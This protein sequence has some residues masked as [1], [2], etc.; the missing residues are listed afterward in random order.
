MSEDP[1][2]DAFGARWVLDARALDPTARDRLHH[3]W[4]RCRVPGARLGDEGVEPFVVTDPD[5]Y[6]VSRAL[7]LASLRRRRG[8]AV[9]LHAA[10]LES[11]GQVVALVGRSVPGS[12]RQR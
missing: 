10:G 6:A 3:L 12:R 9:L 5:P 1:A 2:I 11:G 8:T 4:Q 7:T